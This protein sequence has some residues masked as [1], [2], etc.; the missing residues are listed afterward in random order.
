MKRAKLQ[1][2]ELQARIRGSVLTA[3]STDYD[4][5]RTPW[6]LS[7]EQWPAVVVVAETT[8]DIREAVR[9][10]QANGLKVA[11]KNTGHG[12]ALPANDGMLIVVSSMRG[13]EVDAAKQTAKL[14][15]GAK[16]GDVLEKAQAVGLAPLM[17]SSSDVG[18]IGYTMGGGMGWLARKYGLSVDNVLSYDVVLADGELL[19]VSKKE[20]ENLF[21]GLSG[22]G[23][24]FGIVAAMEVNLFPV[25]T[26]YAGSLTYPREAAREVFARYRE[27]IANIEDEWTTSIAI[28]NLPPLPEVPEFLRGKSVVAVH[29]C[30]VGPIE[31]GEKAIQSWVDWMEPMANQFHP[32]PF[33]EADLISNDPRDPIPAAA[34]NI[35]L[36]DLSDEVVDTLINRAFPQKGPTPL[37]FAE[38]HHGGGA[39]ARI[40]ED[41]IAYSQHAAPF[42]LNLVGLIPTPQM[43][44]AYTEIVQGIRHE[45]E[46]YSTSGAYLN[47]LTGEARWKQTQDAF[48]P[49]AFQ[50][51]ITLKQWYDPENLFCFSLNIPLE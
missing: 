35:I 27:W 22:S 32:L 10:A 24:A 28:R 51:L 7:V 12:V 50:R 45:L 33:T 25:Q 6:I 21:W 26:V 40:D 2:E 4:A 43:R 44:A 3:E 47:F 9:F 13:V 17:G 20:N 14:E 42:V 19:H 29:G 15:A 46:P 34:R 16:W 49:E 37:M 8:S 18:A 23:A 48:S 1:V 11:V 39:M 41:T 31:Q 36:H 5:A 30:Y 38:L